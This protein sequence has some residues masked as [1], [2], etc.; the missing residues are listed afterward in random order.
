[1]RR[2]RAHLAIISLRQ[3]EPHEIDEDGYE[4]CIPACD[5]DLY[6]KPYNLVSNA[7]LGVNGSE[8]AGDEGY[9]QIAKKQGIKWVMDDK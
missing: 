8:S 9:G 6:H 7:P 2:K 5:V 3:I 1:M 4:R